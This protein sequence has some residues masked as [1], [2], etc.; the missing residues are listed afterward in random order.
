[1]QKALVTVMAV[2][3]LSLGN[4]PIVIGA[5]TARTVYSGVPPSLWAFIGDDGSPP[6]D[7]GPPV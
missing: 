1:M 7:D 3:S 4:A 5:P 2:L 6:R